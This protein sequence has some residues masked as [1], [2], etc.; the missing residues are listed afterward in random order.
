[1]GHWFQ[2]TPIWFLGVLLFGATVA[3]AYAGAA[4]SR[5]LSQLRGQDVELSESQQGYVVSS[6]FALLALLLAFTFGSAVD[7]FQTRRQLVVQEANAIEAVYLQAQLL[8]E[9][10][11]S[12]F[13]DLLVRHT[14]NH[15]KLAQLR[16][17]D[18]SA[19]RLLAE[20]DMLLR[21][22]WTATVSAFQSIKTLDFSST[23]V[24]SVNDLVKVNAE[25][26]AFRRTQI[27]A[28]ILAALIFYALVAAAVLGGVMRTR[29]GRQFSIL[30]L[31]LNIFALM[32]VADI[33]RPV[34][35]TIRESQEAMERM[36]ARLKANPPA[37]YQRLVKSAVGG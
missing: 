1:M 31:A 16:H 18:A 10:H 25:R 23:F 2:S 22:I 32:L 6:I 9:P 36:L 8:D 30:L 21:D 34:E 11:R 14:E 4:L 24:G 19:Q 33:N 3:C 5:W 27:P 26:K 29:K 12:R 15:L 13:A 37:I 20:D 7:R 28:T 35:G 17:D